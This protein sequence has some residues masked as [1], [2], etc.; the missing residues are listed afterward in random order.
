M[1][2]IGNEKVM[3]DRGTLGACLLAAEREQ[4]LGVAGTLVA[5]FSVIPLQPA[6]SG[7]ALMQWRDSVMHQA[8]FL[9][10]VPISRAAIALVDAQERRFKGGAVVMAD[11]A[12][13]AYALA[14][15]DA[16]WAHRLP[17]AEI[18]D[19]LA[20]SGAGVRARTRAERQAML[21]RTRVDF[22]LLSQADDEDAP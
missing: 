8:F 20:A 2:R 4:V 7:L 19:A 17:G 14:V 18:V 22:S 5:G 13:L 9:G 15:L 16:V 12:D 10:E 6:E 3:I 1:N 21:K 11:D